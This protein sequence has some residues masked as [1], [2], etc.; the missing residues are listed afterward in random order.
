MTGFTCPKCG[1]EILP[2]RIEADGRTDC[3]FCGA[4][5]ANLGLSPQPDL[6]GAENLVPEDLSQNTESISRKLP[7]LPAKSRIKVVESTSAR[8]VFYIAG[9]GKS[10]AA[11]GCFVVLWNAILC[12]FTGGIVI[13]A[14]QGGGNQVLF[15]TAALLGLFWAVGIGV[16]WLWT[17]M[18]Y[19]RTFILI[20]RDRVVMQRV[21]FNRKK[22]DETLLSPESRAELVESYQQNDDPVYRIEV[23]GRHKAAKFGTSLGQEEKDWLV[24]RINEFLE[25]VPVPLAQPPADARGAQPAADPAA[26]GALQTATLPVVRDTCR[27]CGAPLTGQVVDG[28]ITC[29]QCGALFRTEILLPR[30]IADPDRYERLEPAELPADS[31]ISIDED[32]DEAL[33][34]HY[35]LSAESSSHWI[36]PVVA[37]AVSIAWFSMIGGFIGAVWRFPMVPARIVFLLFTIPFLLAGVV[38]LAIG[39]LFARG[40]TTIRLTPQSLHCRWHAGWLGLTR[41]VPTAEITS[42]RMEF[43]ATAMQNPRVRQPKGA[44][45]SKFRA[46]IVRAGNRSLYL[47]LFQPESLARQV[48]A[49]VRTRLEKFK[50]LSAV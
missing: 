35:D 48:A 42:V 28:A 41:T 47:T 9:G 21:L 32:S 18:K 12:L 45:A 7:A 40:R 10:A 24:D 43:A 33:E 15:P 11:V 46:C 16:A 20:E 38:P 37:L 44:A 26:P 19:E 1:A 3:P 30:R 8:L 14:F 25:V 29:G 2:D 13:G 36:A 4:D 23:A 17:K 39:F 5:L 22:I 50:I 6:A 31:R 27:Q 49:L 34:F